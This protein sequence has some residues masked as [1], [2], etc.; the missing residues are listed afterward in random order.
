MEGLDGCGRRADLPDN[1]A[2]DDSDLL[3][4]MAL[5]VLEAT[6]CLQ[7]LRDDNL[8][9]NATSADSYFA[10]VFGLRYGGVRGSMI[11]GRNWQPAATLRTAERPCESR[12]P[13]VRPA[14][15]S[16]P[17]VGVVPR[18]RD[19]CWCRRKAFV[20]CTAATWT[21]GPARR[22]AAP[23]LEVRLCVANDDELG[24]CISLMF[25]AV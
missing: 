20:R 3:L 6:G 1:L 8:P 4:L 9:G 16:V 22:I 12:L 18:R 10:F 13:C 25:E 14:G 2:T 17:R 24:G 7:P 21:T 5:S 11:A 19:P 23:A 15:L